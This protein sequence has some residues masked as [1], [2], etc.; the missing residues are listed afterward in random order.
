MGACFNVS[1]IAQKTVEKAKT[2]ESGGDREG[3]QETPQKRARVGRPVRPRLTSLKE[4]ALFC[5]L[6]KRAVMGRVVL[7]VEVV[8]LALGMMKRYCWLGH[9]LLSSLL[10]THVTSVDLS[11]S[12]QVENSTLALVATECPSLSHLDVSG[13]ERLTD[14][15]SLSS[16]SNL[17]WLSLSNCGRIETLGR[18]LLCLEHLSVA[19]LASLT[20]LPPSL[21][22]LVSLDVTRCSNLGPSLPQLIPDTLQV[23]L[24]EDLKVDWNWLTDVARKC[25]KHLRKFSVSDLTECNGE[26]EGLAYLIRSSPNLESLKLRD[27]SGGPV[28]AAAL[29]MRNFR[30]L[31]LHNCT[32]PHSEKILKIE[33]LTLISD[34]ELLQ[35]SALE[36]LNSVF[37]TPKIAERVMFLNPNL[38]KFFCCNSS[39]NSAHINIV[40]KQ[41]RQISSL[42]INLIGE[43]S[44]RI[45]DSAFDR[46]ELRQLSSVHLI[47]C[48]RLTSQGILNLIRPSSSSLVD[49]N[50]RWCSIDDLFFHNSNFPALRVLDVAHCHRITSASVDFWTQNLNLNRLGVSFCPQIQLDN[51]FLSK[52]AILTELR[53]D[54]LVLKD[55]VK[56]ID[57]SSFSLSTLTLLGCDSLTGLN[58]I[59]FALFFSPFL[60]QTRSSFR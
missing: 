18:L 22:F 48:D 57:F 23:L 2:G 14:V 7:P 6:D 32:V 10:G 53:A 25:A 40:L 41:C 29:E 36:R 52:C 21:N 43:E 4:E 58:L 1:A 39:V 49:L 3:M 15:S 45:D 28:L 55:S 9:F 37:L 51:V 54:G 11:D 13:C 19:H 60:Y 8:S 56:E 20:D 38:N 42:R 34:G 44:E 17:R 5:L 26:V 35:N 59:Y 33:A 47:G 16:C 46:I 30:E 12:H 24:A 27:V 31:T 50:L